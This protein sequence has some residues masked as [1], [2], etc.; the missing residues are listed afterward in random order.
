MARTKRQVKKHRKRMRNPQLSP[1]EQARRAFARQRTLPPASMSPLGT[2]ASGVATPL[3][4][5]QMIKPRRD[6]DPITVI[7]ERNLEEETFVLMDDSVRN[8][9][10]D[11]PETG[12]EAQ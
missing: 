1:N 2:S 4:I 3:I 10:A 8:P 7:A 5:R 9:E 11:P 12:E 6:P